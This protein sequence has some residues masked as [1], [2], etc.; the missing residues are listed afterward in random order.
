MKK[1]FIRSAG[2]GHWGDEP[3]TGHFNNNRGVTLIELSVTMVIL[4]ILAIG[5]M[6][7]TVVTYKRTKEVEL[8]Q[9][10]RTIRH[11]LDKYKQLV[12]DGKIPSGAMSSG[13]PGDLDILVDGIE[14]DDGPKSFKIKFLRRIPKDPMTED[15]KWGLRSYFDE[16]DS[17]I[18][19][20]QDVYDIYSKSDKK[21]MD[22]TFYKDW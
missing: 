20:E 17:D 8:R 9:N 1:I 14:S 2:N 12:D 7:L 10:L 16:P 22:G 6:P 3:V 4:S 19:G 21:A 5:I 13:Y 11:A 18:W 15:G